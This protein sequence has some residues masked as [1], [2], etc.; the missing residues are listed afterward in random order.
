MKYR[1][2]TNE[3]LA[4]IETGFIKFLA[5]NSVT[6]DDWVKIK[7]EDVEKAEGL[8]EMFSDIVF[9]S[10]LKKV[11]YLEFKTPNDIKNFHCQAEKIEMVGFYIE[12]DA[13]ID[14]RTNMPPQKMMEVIQQTGAK[15]KIY[16]AEKTYKGE[17][18]Q[19]LF[20]MMENG[21]LISDGTLFNTL[22]GLM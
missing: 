13:P 5:A 7:A 8:I 20:R 2:L 22:K 6:A 11:K 21:C 9:D 4:E 12:G 17:R 16:S 15:V 3:E 19:E 1:R 18:E 14:L 10:T